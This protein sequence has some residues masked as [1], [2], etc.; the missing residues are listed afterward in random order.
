MLPW[1]EM[2]KALINTDRQFK[3]DADEYNEQEGILS[4]F[5]CRACKNKGLTAFM[6]EYGMM[7]FRWCRCKESRKTIAQMRAAGVAAD[8]DFDNYRAESD[9]QKEMLRV[10][11][12][13]VNASGAWLF[14]GGQ[15]GAGKTHICTA[16]VNDFIRKG[17]PCAYML[18]KDESRMLKGSVGESEKFAAMIDK[19]KPIKVL[20]IDDF[21]KTKQGEAPTT[22]DINL[23]FELINYRYNNKD[24]LTIVSSERFISEIT[25]IDEAIGSRIYERSN[26][27]CINVRRDDKR[28]YRMKGALV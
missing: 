7:S 27:F 9:W 22:G 2:R 6:N 10:A 14:A 11:K 17:Y 4:G 5:D 19:F 24:L 18:W 16:I 12:N 23:A 15:V 25:L 26:G 1:E 3:T 8:K 13:F 20:Y 28:N 21:L